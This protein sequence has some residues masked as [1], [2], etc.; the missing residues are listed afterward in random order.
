[1]K[2]D[3][4]IIFEWDLKGINDS[5][6]KVELY[7]ND[8]VIANVTGSSSYILPFGIVNFPTGSNT[9]ELKA[10]LDS[11]KLVTSSTNVKIDYIISP[12][13]KYYDITDPTLGSGVMLEL[14]YKFSS[15]T[16]A[17]VPSIN[18][19]DTHGGA[20]NITYVNTEYD[21]SNFYAIGKTKYFI[22]YKD[23]KPATYSFNISYSFTNLDHTLSYPMTFTIK[24]VN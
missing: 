15:N 22:S 1:F 4:S 20:V 10:T 6:K 16:P 5:I 21:N 7:Y 8:I 12:N 18:V 19:N 13:F 3:N 9:F 14:T 2:N 17:S 11:D 23:Y 24:T